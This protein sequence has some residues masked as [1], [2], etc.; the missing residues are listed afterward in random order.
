MPDSHTSQPRPAPSIGSADTDGTEDTPMG[1]FEHLDEL[2]GRLVRSLVAILILFVIAFTFAKEILGFLTV[3]LAAVLDISGTGLH[4]TGPMDF[5]IADI[6][7]GLICAIVFGAPV[8]AYQAWR[9]IEP[10]LYKDERK[11][12]MPF[13]IATVGL[14]FAGVLFC[15][16]VMLPMALD[17]LIGMGLDAGGTAIITVKD[18]LSLVM[19]LMIGFG[20]VFETPVVLM[21]LAFLGLVDADMLAAN[22]KFVVVAILVVGALVTPPDPFS[23]LAMAVPTYLMYE[24][25]IVI[26][27]AVISPDRPRRKAS[28]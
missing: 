26:I 11:Y 25:S 15:Y 9:F 4:F 17:F 20:L 22:R 1:L 24:L 8:W 18:Y 10:A 3:P 23:Q 5:F 6:K 28:S 16:Y 27:R 13:M 21:L 12:V 2:R 14:F 19:I 7:V